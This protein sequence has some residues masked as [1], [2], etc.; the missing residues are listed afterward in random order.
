MTGNAPGE[1]GAARSSDPETS[2]AAAES[3]EP[4]RI[5]GIILATLARARTGQTTHEIAADCG[6]GYQTITPRMTALRAQG[7]VYDTGL[8][9]AWSGAPGSPA[10]TRM[11]IV[12]QLTALRPPPKVDQN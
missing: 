5:H 9:R 1:H 12:W 8:R 7:R 3:V 6:I 2:H 4:S 11:S 10:T